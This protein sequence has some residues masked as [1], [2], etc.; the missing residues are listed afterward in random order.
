VVLAPGALYAGYEAGLARTR[1]AG[2]RVDRATAELAARCA[3]A[4]DALMAA[5]RPGGSGADLYRAWEETGNPQSL[6]PLAHGL[7]LGAEPPLIGLGRGRDAVL[8]EGMVL[9]V[10]SWVTEQGVGGLLERATVHVG[11]AGPTALTRYRRL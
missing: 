3:S 11:S 1:V 9:S 4:M 10:Q 8:E 5:C 7:G 2:R 6:V